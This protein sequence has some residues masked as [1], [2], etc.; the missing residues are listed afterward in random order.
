MNI[1]STSDSSSKESAENFDVS[2]NICPYYS[3]SYYDEPID[4]EYEDEYPDEYDFDPEDDGYRHGRP[5]RRRRRRPRRRRRRRM[6]H[7]PF[8]PFVFPVIMYGDYDDWY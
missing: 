8:M 4:D 1:N 2:Q 5:R 6:M 3:M 7:R